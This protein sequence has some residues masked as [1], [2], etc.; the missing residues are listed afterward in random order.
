MYL[1]G[2]CWKADGSALMRSSAEEKCD[3]CEYKGASGVILL[4][5]R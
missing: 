1:Q 4:L 5:R 3:D 2:V